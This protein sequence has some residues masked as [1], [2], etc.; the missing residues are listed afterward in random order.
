MNKEKFQSYCGRYTKTVLSCSE[1][2][3]LWPDGGQ[4]G[5]LPGD[6]GDCRRLW[7]QT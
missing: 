5:G 4:E 2:G 7:N 3:D 6:G 1:S